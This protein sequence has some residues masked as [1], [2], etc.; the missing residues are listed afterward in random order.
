MN[1]LKGLIKNNFALSSLVVAL[2]LHGSATGQKTSRKAENLF[3]T[4]NK[5]TFKLVAKQIFNEWT[6][7]GVSFNDDKNNI[8]LNY[9]ELYEDDG[10]A[11]GHSYVPNTEKLSQTILA[12]KDLIIPDPKANGATILIQLKGEPIFTINGKQ[13]HSVTVP[14]AGL[15]WK[16]YEIDPQLL[17][18]GKNTLIIGGNAELPI[19]LEENYAKGSLSIPHHPN[20]SAKSKDGGATWNYSGLGTNERLDGEYFVRLFLD[21]YLSKGSLVSPVMDVRDLHQ[22]IIAPTVVQLSP[23]QVRI[24]SNAG[25]SGKI[26][27]KFRT[28]STPIPSDKTWSKWTDF[29]AGDSEIMDPQGGYIQLSIDLLTSDP[30]QTPSLDSILIQ[31][32]HITKEDWYK[33]INIIKSENKKIVRSAI[34]FKY[35]PFGNQK[36]DSLR[37]KYNLDGIVK[38]SATEFEMI[39]RLAGW[40]SKQW[41]KKHLSEFYP[42]WNALE[43][44]KP[45]SDGLPVGGFCLQYNLTFLQAC[46][47]F[48]LVGR[49]ISISPG[50]VVFDHKGGHE[51]VEIWSNEFRKWI[52]VDGNMAWYATDKKEV[53]LSLM[54]LHDRQLD[55]LN[56]KVPK[57]TKFVHIAA[58]AEKWTSLKNW[59]PFVELRMIPRSNFLEETYP[60]PLNQGM[61]GWPWTGHFIWSSNKTQLNLNYSNRVT[62]KENWDW[63]VNEVYAH[64]EATKT[65]GVLRVSLETVTPG[66]KTFYCKKNDNEPIQMPEIFEWV[67]QP[68][69]NKLTVN[70]VNIKNRKG[71]S[72][73]LELEWNP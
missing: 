8:E 36:L 46:E 45:H 39:T 70:S 48:G 66:F 38:G 17:Q 13:I 21:H 6:S 73:Y 47:S 9:G 2:F 61:Y 25:S 69:V 18:K 3:S 11:A 10:P 53:P 49:V 71:P 58:M 50:E 56:G 14:G 54:E 32:R 67:L 68:G 5:K 60:L 64:L 44:L 52:Y 31:A 37:K 40:A 33:K 20:R 35:E 19:A 57:Q 55:V 16:A 34:D 29:R 23:V 27:R 72:T 63:S 59:P 28:G 22:G 7:T 24:M 62:R 41:N 51:V 30:L 26:I 15:R 65:P 1:K 42:A 43:I 4:S 12:R